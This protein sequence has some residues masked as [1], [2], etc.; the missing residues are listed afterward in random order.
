MQKF[1]SEFVIA[2]F[3]LPSGQTVSE[4]IKEIKEMTHL[5]KNV[6][7]KMINAVI[8]YVELK[9]REKV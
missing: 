8:A 9:I 4:R 7:H 2:D 6:R 5:S 1:W 3:K